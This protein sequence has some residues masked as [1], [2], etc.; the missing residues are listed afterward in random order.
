MGRTLLAAASIGAVVLSVAVGRY[1]AGDR[2]RELAT[3]P[4][5]LAA[6]ALPASLVEVEGDYARA[7][8][9]LRAAL[10]ARRGTLRPET[11]A[12]V[13]R[14]LAIIDA[15]IAEARAA[16][17]RDP[18]NQLLAEMLAAGYGR[19]LDLL[20]RATELPSRT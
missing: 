12:Q 5:A 14:S 8:S 16:L 4:S 19:K 18:A 6:R 3:A 7:A 13:E 10:D 11:I 2:E 15:A 20:R 1:L 9:D 17:L